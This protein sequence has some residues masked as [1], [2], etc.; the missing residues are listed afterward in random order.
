[1]PG[2]AQCEAEGRCGKPLGQGNEPTLIPSFPPAGRSLCQVSEREKPALLRGVQAQDMP[3]GGRR[4][5]QLVALHQENLPRPR[6]AERRGHR[7]GRA[8]Q[9]R[10]AAL[11]AISGRQPSGRALGLSP[12]GR[13]LVLTGSSLV[14]AGRRGE[15]GGREGREGMK[16]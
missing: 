5:H 3:G 10:P 8:A 4:A 12:E 9:P 1:M 2:A 16:E 15:E 13:A 14:S 6:Q 11:H 7:H